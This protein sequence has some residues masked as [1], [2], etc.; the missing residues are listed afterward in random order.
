MTE[1]S[2]QQLRERISEYLLMG[3]L[4][5]P[6]AM[7]HDAVRDL[8]VDCHDF[9]DLSTPTQIDWPHLLAEAETEHRRLEAEIIKLTGERDSWRRVAE[10]LADEVLASQASK[11]GF[12]DV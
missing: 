9:L 2:T 5:N 7:N 11:R 8:L 6:E 4:F 3:G 12:I 10:R 1:T